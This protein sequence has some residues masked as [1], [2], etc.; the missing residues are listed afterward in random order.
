MAKGSKS[1]ELY[2]EPAKLWGRN[3]SFW[4][5]RCINKLHK[6]GV[7]QVYTREH[8]L[9]H[10]NFYTNNIEL[11]SLSGLPLDD[12]WMVRKSTRVL[13]EHWALSAHLNGPSA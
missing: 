6:V 12:E 1:G 2:P 8:S 11:A 3:C 7:K 5:I 9:H 13:M 10:D 4:T